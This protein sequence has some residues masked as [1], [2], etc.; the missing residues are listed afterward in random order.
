MLDFVYRFYFT[1]HLTNK[2]Q[3]L[4]VCLSET[5]VRLSQALRTSDIDIII[6]V[7]NLTCIWFLTCV[8]IRRWV[9]R[10]KGLNKLVYHK[11]YHANG[12]SPEVRSP[13]KV[14]ILRLVLLLTKNFHSHKL[15]H[16]D[17]DIFTMVCHGDILVWVCK[18]CISWINRFPC[19]P[20]H[21]NSFS[22]VWIRMCLF[23][24]WPP[25]M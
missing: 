12:F 4:L 2:W 9:F 24:I 3:I 20:S 1:T 15:L 23:Q 10:C 17:M 21:T 11:P 18:M 25:L 16:Y 5:H 13:H 19:K 14:S 6:P 8:K 7:A 22:P